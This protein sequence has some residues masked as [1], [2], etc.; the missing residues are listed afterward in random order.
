VQNVENGYR[1]L[2]LWGHFFHFVTGLALFFMYKYV[3]DFWVEKL[4]RGRERFGGV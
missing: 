4:G 2:R 1:P 3:M